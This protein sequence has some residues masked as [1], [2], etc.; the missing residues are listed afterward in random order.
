MKTKLTILLAAGLFLGVAT[1]A[2]G[3]VGNN[4][5][6]FVMTGWMS[7][8]IGRISVLIIAISSMIG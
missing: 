1:Q 5:A 7:V 6:R 3:R 4:H 8:T 2:Q